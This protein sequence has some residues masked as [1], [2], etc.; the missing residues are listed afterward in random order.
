MHRS[1]YRIRRTLTEYIRRKQG[2]DINKKAM[3]G[4]ICLQGRHGLSALAKRAAIKM[5]LPDK[6]GIGIIGGAYGMIKGGLQKRNKTGIPGQCSPSVLS[7]L[8]SPCL[9]AVSR[10]Q[11]P[12]PDG[13][14]SLRRLEVL[15]R[16]LCRSPRQSVRHR[17][18]GYLQ[19]MCSMRR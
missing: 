8:P 3:H 1:L 11:S 12:R 18:L 2:K 9:G 15:Q 17:C 16:P 4:Q 19:V 5:D 14:L 6:K 10:K 13:L 7:G